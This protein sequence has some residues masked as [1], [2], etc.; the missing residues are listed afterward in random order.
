MGAWLACGLI[1]ALML[2]VLS[3]LSRF[4]KQRA[5]R[6]LRETR[7][8]LTPAEKRARAAQRVAW[9]FSLP[10]D[11]QTRETWDWV[12]SDCERELS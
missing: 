7:S 9:Y 3:L 1:A 4:N 8:Q 6:G 11:R 12:I 2:V 5:L 10:E